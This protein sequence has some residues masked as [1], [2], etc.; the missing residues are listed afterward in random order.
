[1]TPPDFMAQVKQVLQQFHQ[2]LLGRQEQPYHLQGEEVLIDLMASLLR[3]TW[4]AAT[5]QHHE[6]S[7]LEATTGK[8]LLCLGCRT[9]QQKVWEAATQAER[10]RCNSIALEH[11]KPK[12]PHP[13]FTRHHQETEWCCGHDIASAICQEPRP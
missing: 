13:I 7:I 8:K 4:E 10:A 11:R 6:M 5:S 3:A 12:W 2:R 9:L 1:M